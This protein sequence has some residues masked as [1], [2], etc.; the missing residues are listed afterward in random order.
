MIS[1]STV[2]LT[3]GVSSD[4]ELSLGGRPLWASSELITISGEDGVGEGPEIVPS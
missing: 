1:T 4:E 3:A 2:R